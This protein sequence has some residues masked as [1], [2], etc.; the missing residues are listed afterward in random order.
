[1]ETGKTIVY[2]E[3]SFSGFVLKAFVAAVIFGVV[4]VV[5]FS[6]AFD[7]ISW[8]FWRVERAFMVASQASTP[9]LVEAVLGKLA[10]PQNDVSPEAKERMAKHIRTISERWRPFLEAVV[11]SRETASTSQAPGGR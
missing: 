7:S 3:M 10:D 2:R 6:Y 4:Q 9:E 8:R 1:M 5:V 11:L